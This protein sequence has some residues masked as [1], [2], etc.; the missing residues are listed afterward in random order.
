MSFFRSHVLVCCG[1]TCATRGGA[2]IHQQLAKLVEEK[3]LANEVR[4]VETG[5]L[6]ISEHGPAMVV[7]P[8]GVIYARVKPSDVPEIV[9]E[10]LLKGRI[11]QRLVYAGPQAP[12]VEPEV[13]VSYFGK[14]QKIVL[15]NCGVIDPRSID[16]YI[17]V[18]GYQALGKAVT[19][20]TPMEVVA[21]IK[22]SGLRGRG[23]GLPGRLTWRPLRILRVT[24][25]S[26]C[27]CRR[28]RAGPSNRL[29]RRRSDSVVEAMAIG[30]ILGRRHGSL[31][32]VIPAV[33]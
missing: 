1:N 6:G 32:R 23:G 19:E 33:G 2:A 14:Q 16:E 21:E 29:S 22:K 20:M 8:E 15:R 18:G 10:H 9:E 12:V 4:V 17:A 26:W 11:V 3:G 13:K 27:Q 28:R 7:Y 25:R 30:D 31:Y 24:T 5:C